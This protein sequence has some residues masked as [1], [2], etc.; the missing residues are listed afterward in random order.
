MIGAVSCEDKE[1]IWSPNDLNV[2]RVTSYTA[3]LGW[4][5]V[6]DE[7]EVSMGDSVWTIQKRNL[8]VMGLTPDTEF[9]WQV[10]ATKD[11][12]RS[13]WTEHTFKTLPLPAKPTDLNAVASL[14]VAE[15]SWSGTAKEYEVIIGDGVYV[16]SSTGYVVSGL[17]PSTAYTWNVRAI[18]GVDFS[19]WVQANFSTL[20]RPAVPT[21]LEVTASYTSATFTWSGGDPTYELEVV[22]SNTYT[23]NGKEFTVNNLTAGTQYTWRVRASAGDDIY[24]D[25]A[26]SSF[27]TRVLTAVFKESWEAYDG[28]PAW[29]SDVSGWSIVKKDAS[30][31]TWDIDVEVPGLLGSEY[32]TDGDY[33]ALIGFELD[34]DE[35]GILPQDQMLISPA[36]TVGN[37]NVFSFDCAY[38]PI[39]MYYDGDFHFD[40][41]SLFTLK[42]EISADNGQS[43]TELFDATETNRGKYDEENI[44][45]YLDPIWES[46]KLDLSEYA[47]KEVKI[48]FHSIGTMPDYIGVDNISIGI[49]DESA[50]SQVKKSKS[51]S[52]GI[53]LLGKKMGVIFKNGKYVKSPVK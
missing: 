27:S 23:V 25:W 2:A 17:A 31:I 36:F 13:D 30:S 47:G 1:D 44:F 10:R 26:E 39:W 15:L 52:S 18:R 16:T 46:V 51:V 3:L 33:L 37:N 53:S 22:G 32:A 14:R 29:L 7:F 49:L 4:G 9:S 48:A 40:D 42:V 21:N 8:E 6:G 41:A 28:S 5:G 45:D 34:E 11:G 38:A 43:W 35:G 50:N 12:V 24:S 20:A 19:E